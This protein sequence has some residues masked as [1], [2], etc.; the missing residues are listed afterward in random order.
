MTMN[1]RI[2][3]HFRGIFYI[4]L[5]VWL[6]FAVSHRVFAETS[7]TGTGCRLFSVYVENDVFA[8]SDDQYTS[9]LKLTWSRYGLAGLPADA[10]AHRWLYPVV[11]RLGFNDMAGQEAALTFSLGQNIYTPEDIKSSELIRDDRPYAGITYAEIGFHRKTLTHMHTF[12]LCAG[13]VGPHSYAEQVQTFGHDI[14]NSDATNGWDHQLEDEP[15]LCLIYDYKRKLYRAVPANGFGGE[16]IFHTGGGLGNVRTFYNAGIL[17]RYGWNVP[18]D[19]GNFPIQPATC[20]NGNLTSTA[21]SAAKKRFGVHLFISG[22]TQVVL[23]DIFLDGNTFRDSHSVDK[24]PVVGIFMGGVGMAYGKI[25]LTT[26]YV[27]RSKS[28]ETQKDPEVYGSIHLSFH[29]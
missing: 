21:G 10:W 17:M 2:H 3:W 7:D 9:G 15:V 4:A 14:L 16:A 12:G 20:F 13:I 25:K 5:S 23:H 22:C 27:C 26:A 18:G 11:R 1:N 8:D 24:E 6:L 19:F 29:Y 28:F